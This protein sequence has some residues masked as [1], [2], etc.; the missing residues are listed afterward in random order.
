MQLEQ[1]IM[2]TES[3]FLI[4]TCATYPTN[5]QNMDKKVLVK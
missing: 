1:Q 3:E 2:M 5:Q 4:Q